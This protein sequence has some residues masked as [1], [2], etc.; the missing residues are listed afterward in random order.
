MQLFNPTPTKITDTANRPIAGGMAYFYLSGSSFLRPVYNAA[1]IALS[2]PV[3]ADGRGLLPPIYLQDGIPYRVVFTD[4]TG[5]TGAALYEVDPAPSGGYG[6]TPIVP[7]AGASYEVVL[8]DRGSTL[9]RTHTANMND[10]LLSA[11]SAGNGFVINFWNATT[12]YTDTLMSAGGTINGSGSYVIQPGQ[13]V[14][15]TSDGTDWQVAAPSLLTGLHDIFIPAGGFVPATTNGM[16][17]EKI[18]TT[19]NK[20]NADVYASAAGTQE[21]VWGL[22]RVPASVDASSFQ[23][24]AQWTDDGATAGQTMTVGLAARLLDDGGPMDTTLGVAAEQVDAVDTPGDIMS[25]AFAAVTPSGSGRV[26]LWRLYRKAS[27][28][29]ITGDVRFLGL[30]L[31]FNVVGG[32]D[33]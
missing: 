15:F 23:F 11:S 29:T 14:T 31:R 24:S 5:N 17:Y 9:K 2:N 30:T 28:G 16:G 3:V 8:T 22:M 6:T 19:T 25:T 4:D 18:E 32:T 33:A 13:R 12:T 10:T 26:L 27:T 1:G 20:V 7:I 21:Y